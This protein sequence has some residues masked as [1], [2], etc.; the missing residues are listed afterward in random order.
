MNEC[1]KFWRSYDFTMRHADQW[2]YDRLKKTSHTDDLKKQTD[3]SNSWEN[4][5]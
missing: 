1:F 2:S 4:G 5:M 3:A